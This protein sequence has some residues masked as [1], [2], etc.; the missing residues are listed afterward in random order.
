[1]KKVIIF[2]LIINAIQFWGCAKKEIPDE[3][4]AKEPD[5]NE[6][7]DADQQVLQFNLAGYAEDGKK[8]W[9]VLGESANVVADIVKIDNIVAKAYG[10]DTSVTLT[11]DKGEYDKV[12][13]RVKLQ[14]NVVA[15]TTDGTT[16][17]TDTLLWDSKSGKISTDSFVK[18]EK[19]NMSSQGKGASLDP[20]FKEVQFKDDVLVTQGA[21]TVTCDGP[22]EVDYEKNTA[23]FNKNVLV[24]DERGEIHADKMVVFFNKESKKLTRLEAEG[25]VNIVRGENSTFSQKAVYTFDDGKAILTGSPK[26]VIFPE[27]GMDLN[28]ITGN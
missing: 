26:I 6:R 8:K 28:A 4:T 23:I 19:D 13:N 3:K 27:K 17:N 25:N 5:K 11:A 7:G 16:L 22:L 12:N 1:M 2:L 14:D 18:V 15:T 21:T 24:K 20:K 10:A 9:E